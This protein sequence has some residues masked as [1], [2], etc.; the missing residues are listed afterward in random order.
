MHK[1]IDT[2][3]TGTGDDYQVRKSILSIRHGGFFGSVDNAFIKE[4]LPDAH[5]DF[6]YAAI[7]EDLGAILAVIML[8]LLIYVLKLLVTDA[9][10]ARDR[11]VFYAVGGTAALFGI[12]CCINLVSTWPQGSPL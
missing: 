2:L 6:I 9:M 5:T 4:N 1:R 11:F 3:L 8:C 7:V 12:Q 10:N